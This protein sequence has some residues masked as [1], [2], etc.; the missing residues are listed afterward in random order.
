MNKKVI[1]HSQHIIFTRAIFRVVEAQV[2]Y[3]KYDGNMSESLLRLNFERGDSVAMLVHNNED[4]TILL[5]E[6]FKYPT[7]D[8]TGERGDGWIIEIPAGVVEKGESP[9]ETAQRELAEETGYQVHELNYINTFY[10]SPGG[11]SERII[12]YYARVT[13]K[14]QVGE[15]GGLEEEGED[16]KVMHIPFDKAIEMMQ[17]G[18]IPDAKSILALQWLQLRRLKK[19]QQLKKAGGASS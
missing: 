18:K 3:M 11:T 12:L 4:D 19:I 16:I 5:T 6:Q 17:N 14:N 8:P 9:E 7:Y 15:G 2:K 10:V 1:T 13:R